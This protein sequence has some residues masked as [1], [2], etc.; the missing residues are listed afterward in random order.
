MLLKLSIKHP[1]IREVR[2]I[3]LMCAV[4]FS[5]RIDA[6][7]L[8]DL[9][10]KLYKAGFITGLKPAANIVRF[11]PPLIIEDQMINEL[12]E[13]MDKILDGRPFRGQEGHRT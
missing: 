5:D 12:I 13:A 4:E 11:Y 2:G 10:R 1:C 6:A 9:H 7:D 3:G 8:L